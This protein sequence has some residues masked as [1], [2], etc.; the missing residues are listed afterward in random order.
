MDLKTKKKKGVIGNGNK[1]ADSPAAVCSCL[2]S[3]QTCQDSTPVSH[4]T[5]DRDPKSPWSL[6]T[7]SALYCFNH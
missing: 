4:F 2:Q 5:E 7:Y 6:K 3:L 1:T